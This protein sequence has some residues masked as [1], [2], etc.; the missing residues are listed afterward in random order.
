MVKPAILI[1]TTIFIG[2]GT[3]LLTSTVDFNLIEAGHLTHCSLKTILFRKNLRLSGATNK[4]FSTSEIDSI[5]MSDTDKIWDVIW[6]MSQYFE[7]P[8]Q[9]ICGSYLV[10]SAIGRYALVPFTIQALFMIYQRY[11]NEEETA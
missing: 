7:A 11:K 1:I 10:F 5:I 9:V 4:D 6:E 3:R 8:V 2:L